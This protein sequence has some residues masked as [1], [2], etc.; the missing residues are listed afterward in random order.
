MGQNQSGGSGGAGGDK[1]D[2][3]EK[4]RKYEPPVP[5]RVGKK[6]EEAEGTRCCQ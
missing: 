6:E 5:T 1:K 4:K 3:K 2:D